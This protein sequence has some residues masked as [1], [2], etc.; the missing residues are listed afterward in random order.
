MSVSTE[1]LLLI[2]SI[3]GSLIAS[4]LLSDPQ[5]RSGGH[6]Y[7]GEKPSVMSVPAIAVQ[8]AAEKPQLAS[9]VD[10]KEDVQHVDSSINSIAQEAE[11]MVTYTG[12]K[13]GCVL[14]KP[15]LLPIELDFT[16]SDQDPADELAES[17]VYI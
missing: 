16:G 10:A 6:A 3:D 5:V 13:V 1:R 12:P 15:V 4:S 17:C 7:L 11:R 2:P 14:T 9:V 8:Q